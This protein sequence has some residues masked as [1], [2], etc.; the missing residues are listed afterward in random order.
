MH[1]LLIEMPLVI[2]DV[3]CNSVIY[4]IISF[5][6]DHSTKQWQA[7]ICSVMDRNGLLQILQLDHR[8]IT[9]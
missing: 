3:S 8:F 5:H 7:D 1:I 6:V 2:F 4:F 9:E